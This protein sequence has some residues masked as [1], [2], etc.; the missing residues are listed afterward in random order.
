M[1]IKS[2]VLDPIY[3][4]MN[5]LSEFNIVS[6]EVSKIVQESSSEIFDE[7]VQVIV[8]A[9]KCRVVGFDAT[10]LGTTE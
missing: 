4:G 7:V 5:I 6:K 2:I 3:R 1:S 10:P 8:N 9:L